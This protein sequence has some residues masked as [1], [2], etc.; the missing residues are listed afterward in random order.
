MTNRRFGIICKTRWTC[1]KIN[2]AFLIFGIWPTGHFPFAGI[3]SRFVLKKNCPFFW[4]LSLL[5]YAQEHVYR[6][7]KTAQ[8]LLHPYAFEWHDGST[9]LVA[10]GNICKNLFCCRIHR[11]D[12]SHFVNDEWSVD[13]SRCV[14]WIRLFGVVILSD[15]FSFAF[16]CTIIR[17]VRHIN[18]STSITSIFISIYN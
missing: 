13:V 4:F 17:I 14:K 9:S 18:G 7:L 2:C 11:F 8:H 6:N 1:R 16:G 15:R 12:W 5:T 3:T 10:C